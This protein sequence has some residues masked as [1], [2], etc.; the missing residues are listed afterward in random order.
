M[1][2]M[3]KYLRFREAGEQ[4]NVHN[5]ERFGEPVLEEPRFGQHGTKLELFSRKKETP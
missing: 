1:G 3:S 4:A 5:V 2:V